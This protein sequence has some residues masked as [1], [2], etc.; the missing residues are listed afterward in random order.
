[1]TPKNKNEK[2]YRKRKHLGPWYQAGRVFLILGAILILVAA[3][4]SAVDA[5]IAGGV[6]ESYTLGLLNIPILAIVVAIVCGIILLWMGIDNR[7]AY[8]LNLILFA[9]I[10]IVIAI[11]A[12]NVGGLVCIIGGILIIFEQVSKP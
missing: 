10:I 6:F 2:Q 7:F 9:I 1:M 5:S 4:I 11:L 3:I 12:G 8:S